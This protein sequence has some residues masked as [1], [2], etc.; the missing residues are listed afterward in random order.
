MTLKKT[1]KKMSVL[2]EAYLGSPDP[3]HPSG[4]LLTA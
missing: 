3:P 2:A 4:F 1:Y